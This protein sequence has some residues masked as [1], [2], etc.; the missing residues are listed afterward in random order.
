MSPWLRSRSCS[1]T[2]KG[3]RRRR[4]PLDRR[5]RLRSLLSEM[6]RGDAAPA[7]AGGAGGLRAAGRAAGAAA[8][9]RSDEKA[10]SRHLY[11]LHVVRVEE[12]DAGG[13]VR[14]GREPSWHG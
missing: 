7:A 5:A 11:L 6:R 10:I 8:G 3:F 2:T 9:D 1:R 4:K 12:R 13:A 14:A